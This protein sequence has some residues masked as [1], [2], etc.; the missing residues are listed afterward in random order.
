VEN[1]PLSEELEKGS[2]AGGMYAGIAAV[3]GMA[4]GGKEGWSGRDWRGTEGE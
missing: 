3:R 4:D 2:R 1:A